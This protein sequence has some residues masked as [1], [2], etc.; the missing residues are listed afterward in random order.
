VTS[1]VTHEGPVWLYDFTVRKRVSLPDS[2]AAQRFYI[3]YFADA[4]IAD[5]T[6]PA[7]TDMTPIAWTYSIEPLNHAARPIGYYGDAGFTFTSNDEG[8][9][10][11]S[12]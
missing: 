6:T 1:M 7:V 11:P 5:I 8:V 9:K 10:G 3:P 2:T 4:G 12:Q